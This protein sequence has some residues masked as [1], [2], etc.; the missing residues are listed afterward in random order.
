MNTNDQWK[1]LSEIQLWDLM[2]DGEAKLSALQAN[3][4]E[5][6]RILPEK[7]KLDSWGNLGGGFWVIGFIGRTVLW[8]N[9]IEDGFNISGYSKYGVINEYWCNQDD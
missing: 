8:Y 5:K 3:F 1:P 7:W 4:F 6:I 2:N 9:D